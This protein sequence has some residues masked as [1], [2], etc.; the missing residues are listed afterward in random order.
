MFNRHRNRHLEVRSYIDI[1]LVDIHLSF[2]A[3]PS[4]PI[5][6]GISLRQRLQHRA[7]AASQPCTGKCALTLQP[8]SVY[9]PSSQAC[10]VWR[11]SLLDLYPVIP[12]LFGNPAFPWQ[13]A[14]RAPWGRSSPQR[15]AAGGRI[16]WRRCH[17]RQIGA[18]QPTFHGPPG[19]VTVRHR[20]KST[21][22]AR[23]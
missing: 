8:T 2:P 11:Y 19:H 1:Q 17:S 7:L 20:L 18:Q 23:R 10:S 9:C 16:F 6:S 14:R 4:Y 13:G 3:L 5:R 21:G 15:P 12:D 22:G